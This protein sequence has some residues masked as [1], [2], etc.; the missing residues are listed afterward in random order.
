[1]INNIDGNFL[2]GLCSE[3]N[4]IHSNI[5]LAGDPKQ[6]N[7]V[8]KSN[9]AKAL[10][11][12]TSLMEELLKKPLYQINSETNEYN[13]EFITQLIRNYRSHPDI[14]RIPNKLFYGNRLIAAAHKS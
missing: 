9:V 13:N 4:K 7:A 1:M 11:F 5:V 6:L 12:G 3:E 2:S 14:L 8:T 10:G